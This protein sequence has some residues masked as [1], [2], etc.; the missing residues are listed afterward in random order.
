MQVGW[1]GLLLGV[2]GGCDGFA[3]TAGDSSTIP[4]TDS[5]VEDSG[6]PDSDPAPLVTEE[7]VPDQDLDDG[8]IFAEDVIHDIEITLP[9][10][11]W[12][13]LNVDPY[14]YVEGS[15]S[16]DGEPIELVGVRLRGKIGSFRPLSGKPKLK[17]D[18]NQFVEDQ[19]FWGLE[20]LTLNSS[21]VDCAYLKEP[22]GYAVAAAAGVPAS[23]AGWANVSIN[24]SPYG[25]YVLIET[26]DDRLLKRLYE[27]PTGNLYD[28]KYVWYGG[29]SYT[30]L[31]FAQ[32]VDEL[33]QLEEGT[34]VGW[35]DI[36]AVSDTLSSAWGQATYFEEMGEVLS[37]DEFLRELAVEQ[38]IGQNDGYCLNTNNYRVYFEPTSGLAE[39]IPWD[40]DYTFL[41]D[42]QWGMDWA[43]PRG[44]LCYAC[45]YDDTCRAA[46]QA[47]VDEVTTAVEN[48][49]LR[50]RFAA[51]RE[52]IETPASEDPRRECGWSS[53]V[54]EQD[55]VAAWINTRSEELRSWWG[56]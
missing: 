29:Y 12:D 24:G 35:A 48:A 43:N 13:A 54:A 40:F 28:G 1:I 23:R 26:P 56:L 9:Q 53:V 49:L 3:S 11:S 7:T 30:L 18:F 51:M 2:I 14:V 41:Y 6:P 39:I 32:G 22:V 10:A 37:W 20:T 17:I 4:A 47:A 52:L 25:L 42:Y 15:V 27:D 50:P 38:W 36:K 44:N 16:F 55:R 19:R 8:W 5:T 33:Y 31:D 21:V 34:D 46:W 45:R